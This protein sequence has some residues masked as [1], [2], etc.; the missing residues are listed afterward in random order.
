[1]EAERGFSML[2]HRH[3]QQLRNIRINTND[4]RVSRAGRHINKKGLGQEGTRHEG[5]V[6]KIPDGIKF[7]IFCHVQ[8]RMGQ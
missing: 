4:R 1:M 8:Q 5:I 6:G 3:H 2:N 7:A